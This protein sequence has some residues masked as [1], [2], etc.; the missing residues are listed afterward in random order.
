MCACRTTINQSDVWRRKSTAAAM[1]NRKILSDPKESCVS[2]QHMDLGIGEMQWKPEQALSDRRLQT[3]PA[4]TAQKCCIRLQFPTHFTLAAAAWHTYEEKLL[5]SNHS[6]PHQGF[7]LQTVFCNNVLC[8]FAAYSAQTL[9][10]SLHAAYFWGHNIWMSC[11]RRQGYQ[12][13]SSC[14]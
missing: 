7:L 13:I 8:V 2:I 5:N 11:S 4:G 1:Q 12:G 14:L 6:V 10:T 3:T 9:A